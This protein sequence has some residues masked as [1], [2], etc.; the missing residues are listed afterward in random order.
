MPVKNLMEEIVN[1]VVTEILSSEKDELSESDVFKEDVLAYVLNRIPAKYFTSERGILHG[2]L[3]SKFVIQKKADILFL[4]YEAIS[5]V[6]S[7]RASVNHSDYKEIGEKSDFFPHVLGE[8]LE[9]T[10]FSVIPG[11]EV[12]L[13]Y[14]G[15]TAKMIDSSWKNPYRTNNATKG[16][17]HFWPDYVKTSMKKQDVVPFKIVFRHEKF[18]DRDIDIE[19]SVIDDFNTDNSHILP[20]VLLRAKE[21]VDI[22]YLYGE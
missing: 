5:V 14:R 13:T 10:T 15:K 11:V 19:V 9:E 3:E 4:V 2:K 17:F 1:S 22:S 18:E 20:I 12:T 21:G 8:V 16:Y 7:R 6:R